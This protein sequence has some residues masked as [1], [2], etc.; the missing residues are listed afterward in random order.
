MLRVLE[1]LDEASTTWPFRQIAEYLRGSWRSV[2]TLAGQ[3][4]SLKEKL[5]AAAVQQLEEKVD[6]L[7]RKLDDQLFDVRYQVND[8]QRAVA[9]AN[10][11][12]GHEDLIVQ[13]DYTLID[14]LNAAWRSRLQAMQENASQIPYIG[15]R[16]FELCTLLLR[17]A[18][19]R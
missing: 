3:C 6:L 2:L 9:I 13:D 5:A 10:K 14:V 17:R 1:K 8:W 15:R 16:A 7:Y 19:R 12:S 4:P 18:V 11:L